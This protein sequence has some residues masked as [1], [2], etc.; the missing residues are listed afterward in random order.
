MT[1][2]VTGATANIGRLVVDQLIARGATDIR[3]LTI[4][5]GKAALP[6]GVQVARGHLGRPGGLSVA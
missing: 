1:I 4:D 6:E 3:A 5:P 2:L